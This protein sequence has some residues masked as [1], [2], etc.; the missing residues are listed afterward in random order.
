MPKQTAKTAAKVILECDFGDKSDIE[1]L[2]KEESENKKAMPVPKVMHCNFVESPPIIDETQNPSAL[3]EI[4]DE[5]P[6][7]K[8]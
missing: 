4:K 3:D 7:Q 1:N 6:L 8:E 5:S 2:S